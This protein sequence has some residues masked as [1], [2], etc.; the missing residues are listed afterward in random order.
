MT[1]SLRPLND[2]SSNGQ[3][4][5]QEK[6]ATGEGMSPLETAGYIA[7]FSAELSY[8]ARQSKLDLLA[9]L[10][11]MARLEAIRAVRMDTKDL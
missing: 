10:L 6:V 11:D 8:L 1:K 2:R 4:E 7:E 5:A 3:R 9:Y